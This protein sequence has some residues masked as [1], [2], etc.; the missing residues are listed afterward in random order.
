VR[1]TRL[2]EGCTLLEDDDVTSHNFAVYV[3]SLLVYEYIGQY[4]VWQMNIV[5]TVIKLVIN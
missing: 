3:V 4:I 5:I 1:D 2:I